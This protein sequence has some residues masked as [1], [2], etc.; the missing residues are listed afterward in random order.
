MSTIAERLSYVEAHVTKHEHLSED[1][2]ESLRR[3]EQRV[4]TLDDKS[5]RHFL[6]VVGMQMTTLIALVGALLSRM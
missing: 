2:R 6:W 3:I 1:I 5:S 4:D